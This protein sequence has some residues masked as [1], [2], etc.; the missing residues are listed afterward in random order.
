MLAQHTI[1]NPPRRAFACRDATLR[2]IIS[3]VRRIV[4]ASTSSY[5]R[6]LLERFGIP[7]DVRGPQGVDEDSL[8]LPARELVTTLARMKAESLACLEPNAVIIGSDQVAALDGD[9]LTKPGTSERACAQ[10]Q[11]LA[12]R[13]HELLTAVCVIDTATGSRQEH[14]DVHR[15]RLRALTEADIQSYVAQELP[16]DC[17]GSYKVEGLGISLMDEISGVDFTAIVGLPLIAVRR[18][19]HNA[20]V[21]I[22]GETP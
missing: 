13:T 10:L 11:R 7:F 4:L 5:R 20:G 1:A 6:L 12:G 3:A 9:I 2:G 15:I 8:R 19:L 21:S 14:L 16:L 17:A 18:M 22:P